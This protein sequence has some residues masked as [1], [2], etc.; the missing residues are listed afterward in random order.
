MSDLDLNRL[1]QGHVVLSA[2]AAFSDVPAWNLPLALVGLVLVP[3]LGDGHGAE[4]VR[5]FVL[6][7]GG[8]VLLDVVWFVSHSTHGF[9]RL[10]ILLNWLLKVRFLPLPSV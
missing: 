3:Q 2:L 7:L 6:A 4:S 10:V 5:Q 9:V 8:S 1:L